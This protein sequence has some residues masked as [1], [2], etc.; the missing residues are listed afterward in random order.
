MPQWC[1]LKWGAQVLFEKLAKEKYPA[2]LNPGSLSH[3]PARGLFTD[4]WMRISQRDVFNA[5]AESLA[6]GYRILDGSA[7]TLLQTNSLPLATV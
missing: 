5:I 6:S 1:F 3:L 4:W 7:A 2:S